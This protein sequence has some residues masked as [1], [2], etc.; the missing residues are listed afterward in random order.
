MQSYRAPWAI[1]ASQCGKIERLSLE[2]QRAVADAG[3]P[4]LL[5]LHGSPDGTENKTESAG[6][7]H[8]TTRPF[9]T[10]V[11]AEIILE[12]W[13]RET[14]GG[15]LTKKLWLR[16]RREREAWDDSIQTV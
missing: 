12:N 10:R 8:V 15:I 13:R 9:G 1:Q 2:D 11:I 3:K 14:T 6:R 7:P 16:A 4:T 5:F